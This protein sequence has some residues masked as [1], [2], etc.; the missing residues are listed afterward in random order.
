M[1]Y[2]L[3]GT[4]G[5]LGSIA[6]YGIGKTISKHVNARFPVGTFVINITGAIMLGILTSAQFGTNMYLFLGDGFLGAYTT[7]STFMYEGFNLFK[8]NEKLNAFVYTLSSVIIG[9]IGFSIGIKIGL[10]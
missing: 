10:L 2:L 6:R 1:N 3:V 7:F 4:G 9:I 5:I 8:D